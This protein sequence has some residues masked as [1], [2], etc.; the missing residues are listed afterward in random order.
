MR[1]SIFHQE[2]LDFRVKIA[3][4]FHHGLLQS[5]CLFNRLPKI[6]YSLFSGHIET[7][8]VVLNPSKE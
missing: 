6:I 2:I 5:G 8:N 3:L 7:R 4:S 1:V